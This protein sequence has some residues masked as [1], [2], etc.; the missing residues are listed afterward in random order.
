M[1]QTVLYNEHLALNGKIVDF[2]GWELPVLYTSIIDEHIAARTKAALFD[3]S[4]MGEISVKGKGSS[5]FLRRMIP[6]SLDR[7]EPGRCMYSCLC[8]ERGGIL[9]DLFI[10]MI[11]DD[12]YLLVVNASTI[13]KDYRWLTAHIFG[14][15]E[16]ENISHLISKLDLQG[17]FSYQIISDVINDKHIETLER[18]HFIHSSFDSRPIIVSHSGYTGESGYEMYVH[19]DIAPLLWRT[20][21]KKGE[22]FGLLPAGLGARDTLRLEACYSLYGHELNE[23]TTPIESGIG[24]I[25]NSKDEYIGKQVLTKQKKNGAPRE[26]VCLE[27]I[28]RGVPRENCPVFLNGTEIGITTSGGF[29]PTFKKGIALALI[30][31]GMLPIGTLCDIIIRARPLKAKTVQRPFYR[32]QGK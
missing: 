8:N 20:I 29:S 18:F 3:V 11:A 26:I 22:D 23:N 2:A 25:V 13:E 16:I 14:D 32:Y 24:W 5:E 28:D 9:D 31:K 1:N 6:S 27:L 17:P 15:V 4:H 7:L 21:M 10:Y 30:K 12:D 19:N